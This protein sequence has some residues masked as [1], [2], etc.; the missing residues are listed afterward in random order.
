VYLLASKD[1]Q[2]CV[3]DGKR[4]RNVIN[5]KAGE[6]RTVRGSSPWVIGAVDMASLQMYFQGA[7]VFVP[8]NPGQ[9]ILLKEQAVSNAVQNLP[10]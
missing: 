3:D 10:Q 4:V 1:V 5:L 9:R 2:V 8:P 6:G 7:K